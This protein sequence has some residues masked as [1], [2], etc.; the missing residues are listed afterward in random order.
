MLAKPLS[1]RSAHA[2]EWAEH[3]QCTRE[4]ERHLAGSDLVERASKALVISI[5][6]QSTLKPVSFTTLAHLAVSSTDRRM[7]CSGVP[8]T[9]T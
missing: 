5:G 1:V 3:R 8:P 4:A 6:R 9:G 2:A 7:S